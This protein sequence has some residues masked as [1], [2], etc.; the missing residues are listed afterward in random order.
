MGEAGYQAYM[1]CFKEFGL[2]N[3]FEE[4]LTD[5]E[6]VRELFREVYETCEFLLQAIEDT[7]S[8]KNLA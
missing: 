7:K 2:Q 6:M 5:D 3:E 1:E 4:Y 8:S